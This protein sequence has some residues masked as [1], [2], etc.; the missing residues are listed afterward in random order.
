VSP[1][2][3]I[4]AAGQILLLIPLSACERRMRRTG[5]P[6]IIPFEL[7][8]TPE[9]SR[10]IIETW[11]PSGQAAARVSLLLD[12]P[13]LLTYSGLQ[14][15]GCRSASRRLRRA[16]ATALADA[17]RVI[18]PLQLAAGAFDA[19]ENTTLLA[20]LAGRDGRLPGLAR[21]FASVKFALLGLGWL[22]VAAGLLSRRG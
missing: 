3:R 7:A 13:F 8:G 19:A 18:A 5:G 21:F 11:G 6:G 1:R 20:I 16:G 14:L 4:L 15:D 9:R 22:Y 2:T 10:K 12:Y 17:G